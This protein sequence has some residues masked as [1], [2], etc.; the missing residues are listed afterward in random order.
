MSNDESL[1][2]LI[3]KA[4]A[5]AGSEYKLAKLLGIP[6]PHVSAWKSGKRTCTPGDRARLAG[7]AHE[8]AQQE[9]ARATINAATGIKREQLQRL[10]G[11]LS[12]QTGEAL[13]SAMLGTVSLISGLMMLDIPRCIKR[14]RRFGYC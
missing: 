13:L 1:N 2:L 12:H 14:S 3:A 7:F 5:I 4:A 10:L 8:D 6:Q 11:K 9:L